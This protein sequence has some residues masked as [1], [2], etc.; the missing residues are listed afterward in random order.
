MREIYFDNSATT[1]PFDEVV[2][3]VNK[4]ITQMYHNPSSMYNKGVEVSRVIEN[5]RENIARTINTKG[6]NIIFTS[7]GTESI[8]TSINSALKSN[9]GKHIITTE[10]EHDA[11]L[12]TLKKYAQDGYQITYVK[13]K[14][15]KISIEDI[16]GEVKDDTALVSVMHVNN[17]TGNILDINKLG[18]E[19]K[20]KNP[21]TLF[22]IDAV[23]SYMKII[24]DVEKFKADFLSISGHKIHGIKGSGILYVKEPNRLV[25]LMHGGGQ[26]KGHRSGTENTAG[27]FALGK[28]VEINSQ[29]FNE[30]VKH[31]QELKEYLKQEILENI[32]RVMVNSPE[33][34]VCH[35]LNVSFMGVK[36]E[37]LLHTLE[38]NG[39]YVS[40]GSACSSKKKGS[41]VLQSLGLKEDEIQGAI[42]FSLSSLNS[43]IEVDELIPV[44]KNAVEDIRLITRFGRR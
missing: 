14:N 40:T 35:I 2:V 31:I 38:S 28:A 42:R 1:K 13:P 29:S 18:F 43:K 21:K 19:I 44:L 9:R 26:E 11:T 17:E 39:I 16:I 36:A 23:Q 5:I 3:S 24:L 20:N 4:A 37:I 27:I 33:D 6:K 34:G 12:K 15:G 30:N 7:G 22:H 25:P 10:Y 41:H 32:D 8:N